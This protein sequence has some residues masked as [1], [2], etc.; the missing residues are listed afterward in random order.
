MKRKN[1]DE[2]VISDDFMFSKVMRDADLCKKFIETILE[3][4]IRKIEYPE[5]QKIIDVAADSKSIRLDIYVEDDM[6]TVYDMEMQSIS[7]DNIPKRS[8]YYQDL[9]DLDLLEKGNF[10]SELKKSIV[11]FICKFDLFEKG[12]H[13]YTFTNRC[14]EDLT[15]E[16]GDETTKIFINTKGTMDDISP[17]TKRLLDY[18]EDNIPTDDFTKALDN[19]VSSARLNKQWRIEYMTVEAKIQESY[20]EGLKEGLEEGFKEANLQTATSLLK[21]TTLTVEEI[22]FNTGLEVEEVESL[23]HQLEL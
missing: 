7:V 17:E 1:Y 21:A 20:R 10:Y 18:I 12:R 5:Y 23:K 11:I 9:M 3:I 22:A 16:L 6:N 4:K 15:V 13:V 8:R 14:K 2:L 19:A